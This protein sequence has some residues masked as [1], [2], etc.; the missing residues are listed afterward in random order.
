MKNIYTIS[1]LT[2]REALSKKIFLFFF[3]V[4]TFVI[5]VFALLFGFVSAES[6]SGGFVN[7]STTSF[8]NSIA[9]GIKMFIIYP[10]YA[11]GLFLSIFSV[12]GFIPTL[13]EKGNIDLILSKPVSRPQV[14]LGKFFGGTFMV[15]S[16]IFYAIFMLWILIGIKF[17]V[18]EANFL[19]SA[20]TITLAFASIYSII[21]LVGILSKS[22][23]FSLV[24]SYM[25]FFIFSP[26]LSSR[27]TIFAFIDSGFWKTL[28][29]MLYYIIPQTSDLSTITTS[30]AVGNSVE[31]FDSIIFSIVYIIL[32][33]LGAIFI[34]R[35]KDY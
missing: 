26:I 22:S 2:F 5:L 6:F 3:S 13:L 29:E 8:D 12:A 21:I 30:F 14:I 4:S 10:L 18:W 35:K 28:F 16:N 25:I 20:F 7:A 17:S 27:D 19:L 32:I 31:N 1:L 33:L 34:F 11:G 9:N 23:T 24:I 15:F